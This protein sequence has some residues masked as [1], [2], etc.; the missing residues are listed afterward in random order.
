MTTPLRQ[1]EADRVELVYY[2]ALQQLGNASAVDSLQIFREEVPSTAQAV[3]NTSWLVRILQYL[4]G[5][6]RE[7]QDLAV[8][9]YRLVSALRTGVA[10]S[11]PGEVGPVTLEQLRREFEEVVDNIEV[12]TVGEVA[13]NWGD[14]ENVTY[15]DQPELDAGDV[16]AE[17]ELEELLDLDELLDDMN[18]ASEQ[19]AA[20]VLDAL[21]IENFVTKLDELEGK[22]DAQAAIS[23]AFEQA[24]NR[25]AAAA[26]RITQNAARGLVYNLAETDL[27]I[28]GWARFSLTGKPC[29]WCAMLISRGLAYKTRKQATAARAG[30]SD[31]QDQYHDNCRCVAVPIFLESQMDSDMFAFTREMSGLWRSRIR[32]KYTGS[33]ALAEF[34]KVIRERNAAQQIAA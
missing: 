7:T 26:M 27:R 1:A 15:D 2:W 11:L 28:I 5:I 29:G 21:G 24:A 23:E 13:P 16:D 8:A 30:R 33:D 12:E 22:E 25:Q 31:E 3:T 9:Y 32:G 17:I 14:E 6:R 20:T 18:A 19:E 34:R 4:V 10:P